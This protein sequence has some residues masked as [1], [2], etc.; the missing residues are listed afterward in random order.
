MCSYWVYV[1]MMHI[2]KYLDITVG[3]GERFV[4]CMWARAV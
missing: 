4:D 2:E 1:G 3:V